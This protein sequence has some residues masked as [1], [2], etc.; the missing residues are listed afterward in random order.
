[1]DLDETVFD[2]AGYQSSQLRGNLA[3]DARSWDRWEENY[4]D[5]VRLV[6]GA[7]EFI[8]AAETLGYTVVHVS[9]RKEKYRAQARRA[10]D[11]LGI[12]IKGDHQLRLSTDTSDKT[13]RRQ[14]VE[15]DYAVLLLVGDNLRDFDEQFKAATLRDKT[16]AATEA[17]IQGRKDRVDATRPIWGD[18]W[19]IIPNP[20]YGEWTRPLGQGRADL[21]RLAPSMGGTSEPNQGAGADDAAIRAV[22]QAYVD[23][24]GSTTPRQIAALFTADADQLVS[25]GTRRQG[26]DALVR[27][28]IDSSR[29]NP[30]SGRSPSGPSASSPPRSPSS[31]ATTARPARTASPTAS[32]RP[33]SPCS[34]PPKAGRSPPSATCSR[35]PLSAPRGKHPSTTS[36]SKNLPASRGATHPGALARRSSFASHL[37]IPA[38]PLER[39]RSTGYPFA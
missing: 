16:A 32:C 33:P 38:K 39:R 2:N 8:V 6:P 35:R 34:G 14:E 28:M 10:L 37:E 26:R 19:I 7:K 5:E 36:L 4:P 20:A 18:R 23:A 13:R 12:P 31:T 24:R 30:A 15:R 22:V 9:N 3:F 11:R 25:D 1:M 21:D 29:R 17:V 27:G